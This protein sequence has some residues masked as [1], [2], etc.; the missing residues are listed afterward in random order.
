VPAS[1]GCASSMFC[2][3]AVAINFNSSIQVCHP[4]AGA[5]CP[6]KDLGEP[7]DASRSLR[8]NTARLARILFAAS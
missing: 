2:S 7:R 4:E 6:P 3:N 1:R 8:R 5:L